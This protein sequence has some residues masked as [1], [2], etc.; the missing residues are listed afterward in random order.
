MGTHLP[1]SPLMCFWHKSPAFPPHSPFRTGHLPPDPGSSPRSEHALPWSSCDYLNP[2]ELGHCDLG[3]PDSNCWPRPTAAAL[4]GLSCWGLGL[5]QATWVRLGQWGGFKGFSPD[6]PRRTERGWEP[7][8]ANMSMKPAFH[9]HTRSEQKHYHVTV[10]ELGSIL[11]HAPAM[12]PM[13]W[14]H[15]FVHSLTLTLRAPT[16]V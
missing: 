9:Q 11:K 12:L 7:A 2:E 6:V 16:Q 1:E 4:F 10:P 15:F 13:Q 14:R 3:Q 8:G 5:V